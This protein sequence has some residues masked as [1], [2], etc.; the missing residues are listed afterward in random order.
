D[1][2]KAVVQIACDRADLGPEFRQ[3]LVDFVRS[4]LDASVVPGSDGGSE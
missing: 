2:L 3:W 4:E 1:Y